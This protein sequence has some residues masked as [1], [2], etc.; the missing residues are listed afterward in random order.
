MRLSR[1]VIAAL[2]TTLLLPLAACGGGSSGSG[3]TASA[4]VTLTYWASNQ[5]TSLANDKEVLTPELAKFTAATGVK[6][7]V[8]VV[9]WSD[10]LNRVL[11]ATTS[12]K[13]PDVVNIGNTWSA[14]VQA[15]GA[16]LPFGD[17]Q[18]AAVGGKDR[19]LAGSLAA[20]GAAG[21]PPTALP[22]Y[23]EA[24]GLYYNKKQFAAAGISSPPATWEELIADG[25]KLTTKGHWGLA[26]QGGSIPESIH[27]A[28]TF[29]QQQG[30]SFFDSAGKPTFDTPQNVA[31]ILQY[32][33]TMAAD[34]IVNPSDAEYSNGTEA[35]RDYATGKASMLM[36]QAASGSLKQFGMNEDD[37]GVAPVPPPATLPAGGKKVTSMVAGINLGIFKNTKHEDA[38]LKF[39]KFMTSTPTQQSLNKTYGSLPSVTEAYSDPAFQTPNVQVF[40]GVLNSTAAPLPQVAGESQFE[41]LVGT[42][43]KNLWA[44]AASGKAIDA[45]YVKSKLSAAQQQ[46]TS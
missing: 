40:R 21:Q 11:A 17:S 39:V 16:L 13:G 23:S 6:V 14:S 43:I 35:L 36:W 33:N 12:G 25:K 9:P 4:P 3:G 5:G 26:V 28:F 2:S 37:I 32:V 19:F 46:F 31:G 8:E 44:D 7:N 45:A 34:K 1:A 15:T 41:T 10:L 20:T 27:S 42:V 30:G 38:A 18:M 29:S 22:I 24:Y